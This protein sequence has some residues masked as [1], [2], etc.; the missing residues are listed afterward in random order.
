[1]AGLP[2]APLPH[3]LVERTAVGVGQV[4]AR[5][6]T[7]WLRRLTRPRGSPAIA[8]SGGGVAERWVRKCIARGASTRRVMKPAASTS[9]ATIRI[10]LGRLRLARDRR[11]RRFAIEKKPRANRQTP[12]LKSQSATESAAARRMTHPSQ[13]CVAESYRTAIPNRTVSRRLERR[14]WHERVF[15]LVHRLRSTQN[16]TRRAAPLLR[17]AARRFH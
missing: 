9:N 5:T 14:R 16:D 13:K 17:G 12:R 10:R 8:G 1:M 4:L 11:R 15:G 3:Q 2:A 7:Q 6:V